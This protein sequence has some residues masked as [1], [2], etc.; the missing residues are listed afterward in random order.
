MRI[1]RFIRHSDYG[2]RKDK[3]VIKSGDPDPHI[4]TVSV[5]LLAIR[6]LVGCKSTLLR[7]CGHLWKI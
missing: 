7:I 5:L 6:L 3:E 2:V 1:K 4:P